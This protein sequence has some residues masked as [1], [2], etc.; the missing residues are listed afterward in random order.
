M[1][2]TVQSHR[3]ILIALLSAGIALSGATQAQIYKYRDKDGNV[4]FSDTPPAGNAPEQVEQVELGKTNTTAPP[5]SV[6][7]LESKVK[8]ATPEQVSYQ[9]VITSPADGSTIPMGP[10]NFAVTANFTPTLGAGE[11]AQL[12]LDGT[13]VGEPQRGTAWSLS[14]VFRGEHKLVVQRLGRDGKTIDSSQPV[15]V[16]VMRPSIR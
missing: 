5:P 7:A 12:M 6:P 2:N 11:R 13:A 16:Y 4:V 8:T 9:T 1:F 3:A 15:T 14:N 10:G